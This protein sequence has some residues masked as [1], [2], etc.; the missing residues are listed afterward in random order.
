MSCRPSSR[1][2][3]N[4]LLKDDDRAIFTAAGVSYGDFAR[5]DYLPFGQSAKLIEKGDL[6]ATLQSAGLGVDSIRQLATCGWSFSLGY[7]NK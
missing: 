1:A 5:T 6:D 2:S 4:P 3:R 7:C